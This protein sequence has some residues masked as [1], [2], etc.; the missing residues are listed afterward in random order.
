MTKAFA[1]GD[2]IPKLF[3]VLFFFSVLSVVKNR[4]IML[5]VPT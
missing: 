3:S 2:L 5:P 1:T 4:E